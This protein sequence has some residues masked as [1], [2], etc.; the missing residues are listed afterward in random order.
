[1]EEGRVRDIEENIAD[2]TAKF[3][4][5]DNDD[6]EKMALCLNMLVFRLGYIDGTYGPDAE[7]YRFVMDN[8]DDIDRYLY[9]LGLRL[10]SDD[11]TRQ[12]WISHV[13]EEEGRL[14]APFPVRAMTGAQMVLLAILQKRLAAGASTDNTGADASTGVLL[15]EA[16]ILEDMFPY[17]PGREDEK[18]KRD[19]AIAAVRRFCNELGL[20]RL[21]SDNL[22]QP[23]GTYSK[24]YRISPFIQHQFDVVEMERLL[25]SIGKAAEEKEAPGI[26]EQELTTEEENGSQRERKEEE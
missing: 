24:V 19:T 3:N 8:Y 1:M 6:T 22:L 7:L 12:V 13:A 18:Y 10:L 4:S 23:D 15:S 26:Q 21:V 25:D 11:I 16:D 9:F 20:L 17:I 2:V 5:L 14:Y